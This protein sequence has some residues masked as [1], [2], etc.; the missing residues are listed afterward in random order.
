MSDTPPTPIAEALAVLT[1]EAQRWESLSRQGWYERDAGLKQIDLLER[2]LAAMTA[3]KN[4]AVEALKQAVDEVENLR[5]RMKDGYNWTN[6]HSGYDRA[7]I[8]L[9]DK[10]RPLIAELEEVK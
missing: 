3:A 4:K 5:A 8:W 1:R 7:R 2:E 9:K 10:A 6:E